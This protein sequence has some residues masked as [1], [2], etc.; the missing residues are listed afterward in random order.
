MRLGVGGYDW[1][2]FPWRVDWRCGVVCGVV[3]PR[4]L[5]VLLV[6]WR[7]KEED[8]EAEE[9]RCGRGAG[10]LLAALLLRALTRTR[11]PEVEEEKGMTRDVGL[12]CVM[13]RGR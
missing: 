10:R 4:L 1:R 5:L 12:L 8:D 3:A 11:A 2:P 6:L 13:V 9:W 7:W